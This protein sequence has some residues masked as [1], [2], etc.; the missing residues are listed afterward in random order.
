MRSVLEAYK[1]PDNLMPPP[2][3]Q[4]NLPHNIEKLDAQKKILSAQRIL[5][6]KQYYLDKQSIM[7]PIA[8]F[9]KLAMAHIEKKISMAKN[10]INTLVLTLKILLIIL[11]FFNVSMIWILRKS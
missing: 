10:K 4:F 9:N 6:D 7:A 1:V 2:I 8:T 11:I 5:Y 3:D